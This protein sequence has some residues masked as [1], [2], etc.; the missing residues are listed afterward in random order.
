MLSVRLQSHWRICGRSRDPKESLTAS[1][2]TAGELF[3]RKS[4][5][6]GS[7]LL[8]TVKGGHRSDFFLIHL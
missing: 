1:V 7:V 3:K 4:L 2:G 5:V 6:L 8:S